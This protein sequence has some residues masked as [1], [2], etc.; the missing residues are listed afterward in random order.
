MG[1]E[2]FACRE[3]RSRYRG[4]R[5]GREARRSEAKQ[6]ECQCQIH[7]NQ[8]WHHARAKSRD[9]HTRL[10]ERAK[11]TRYRAHIG[12]GGRAGECEREVREVRQE[13]KHHAIRGYQEGPFS[14]HG[15]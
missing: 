13:H 7:S 3:A 8:R 1:R 15:R 5:E 11:L 9:K 10:E 12:E 6:G 4:D 14:A 2:D